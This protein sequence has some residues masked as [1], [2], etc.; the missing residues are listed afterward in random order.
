[1]DV[2]TLIDRTNNSIQLLEKSIAKIEDRIDQYVATT[3]KSEA[4]LFSEKDEFY[5]VEKEDLRKKEEDLRREKEDLRNLREDLR[6]EEE[7]GSNRQERVLLSESNRDSENSLVD[8][9]NTAQHETDEQATASGPNLT[10][11]TGMFYFCTE[12]PL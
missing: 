7:N 1:M 8:I 4:Q 2:A 3:N 10:V 11:N 6:R 12:I 5:L 9:L